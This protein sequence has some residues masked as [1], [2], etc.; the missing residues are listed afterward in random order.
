MITNQEQ[1]KRIFNACDDITVLAESIQDPVSTKQLKGY[2]DIF[3]EK[4]SEMK[5]VLAELEKADKQAAKQRPNKESI[6]R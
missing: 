4:I 3:D 2:L 5:S 1:S 6:E